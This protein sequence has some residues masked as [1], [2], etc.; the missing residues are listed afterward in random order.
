MA[1]FCGIHAPARRRHAH[2]VTLPVSRPPTGIRPAPCRRSTGTVR[3]NGVWPDPRV[4]ISAHS[5]PAHDAEIDV[6]HGL[7]PAV[8]A[9]CAGHPDIQPFHAT[10]P[11]HSSRTEEA[12]GSRRGRR[13]RDSTEL[14]LPGGPPRVRPAMTGHGNHGAMGA[15]R[16]ERVQDLQ[17]Q[18]PDTPQGPPAG[19]S[20]PEAL[21]CAA[22]R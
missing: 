9:H 22:C 15:D 3:R 20:R 1:G 6:A 8:P 17:G 16:F 5:L 4:P 14:D 18:T 19:S 13:S 11:P 10:S 21:P 7:V 2:S 12:V